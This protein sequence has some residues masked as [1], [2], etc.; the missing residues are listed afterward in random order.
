MATPTTGWRFVRDVCRGVACDLDAE[1]DK[2]YAKYP[3]PYALEKDYSEY[4]KEYARQELEK[5]RIANADLQRRCFGLQPEQLAGRVVWDLATGTGWRTLATALNGPRVIHGFERSTKAVGLARRFAGLLEIG[6]VQFH[7]LSLFDLAAFPHDEPP[8]I[9]LCTGALHHVFDLRRVIDALAKCCRP[10]TEFYFTHSSYLSIRGV[11]EYYKKYRC[12]AI[13]GLDLD[14]RLAAGER[15]WRSQVK[16]T[17]PALRVDHINDLAGTF[18]MMRRP[19]TIHR[20]FAGTGF[21]VETLPIVRGLS[22]QI[23]T[24][25]EIAHLPSRS[26]AKRTLKTALRA[27]TGLGRRV[28]LPGPIDRVLGLAVAMLVEFRPFYFKAVYRG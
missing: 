25:G 14:K 4:T 13:G 1:I 5:I 26:R 21:E 24:W 15:V 18:Y 28:P 12:W 22:H 2:A 20:L 10:G 9:V 23:E 19:R 17:P 27:A 11:I 16:S 7:N 3:F 8:D 6:N